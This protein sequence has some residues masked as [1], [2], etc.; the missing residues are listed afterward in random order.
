VKYLAHNKPLAKKLRLIN[1]EKNNQPIPTW[2]TVRTRLKVRRPY[3]LR[4]WRRNKLKD[5]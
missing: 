5:V 4:N 2:I 1:R 3:R